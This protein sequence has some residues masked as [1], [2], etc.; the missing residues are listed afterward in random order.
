MSEKHGVMMAIYRENVC[1][2]GVILVIAALTVLAVFS[3][4]LPIAQDLAYHDFADKRGL[5]RVPYF[6][7]VAS[8]LPFCIF[9][10]IG[11][12]YVSRHQTKFTMKGEKTLWQIFFLGVA[13]V[14]IG[15]GYYHLHPDNH[16]LVWDRLPMTIAFMS[17]F[18]LVI[19]E[20]INAK[21]GLLLAP[22]LLMIGISSVIYW[23]YTESIGQGDLRFYALVQ[24]LPMLLIPLLLVLF[25]P[26]YTG[27]LY[28]GYTV[29]W[30]VLAKLLEHFDI[31]VFS[32]LQGIVSGHSLKHLAA[33]LSVYTM[34]LYVKKRACV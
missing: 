13:L 27:L 14:G 20:R 18:S 11:F 5:L 1:K 22:L 4:M 32:L 2:M 12:Y 33:S 16:T 31:A 9:G 30:Y 17:F 19:M 3:V 21:A 6:G 7:D 15:S 8:N 23:D 34:L 25:P 24:F 28:L 26:R 29:G 10:L